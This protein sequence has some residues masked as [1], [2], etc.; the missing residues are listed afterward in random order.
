MDRAV[1]ILPVVVVMGPANRIEQKS[2]DS[3]VVTNVMLPVY[4]VKADPGAYKLAPPHSEGVRLAS[5]SHSI[6]TEH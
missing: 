3:L 2:L 4:P 6:E 5:F 1:L